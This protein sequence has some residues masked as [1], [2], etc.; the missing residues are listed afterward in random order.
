[1]KVFGAFAVPLFGVYAQVYGATV[2]EG[3]LPPLT[4]LSSQNGIWL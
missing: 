2:P 4:L 3:V 1:V